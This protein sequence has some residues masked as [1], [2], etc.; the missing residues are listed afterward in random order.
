MV[1]IPYTVAQEQNTSVIRETPTERCERVTDVAICADV[2]WNYTRFPNMRG[3]A[4]LEEANRELEQFRQ[5]IETNCSGG[6][7]ILLCSIYT[8]FCTED[9]SEEVLFPPCMSLCQYVRDGCEP[10]FNQR[11]GGLHWPDHLNCDN[12]DSDLCFGPSDL[13]ELN[14]L[15]IPP[16]LVTPGTP[17]TVSTPTS[18]GSDSAS[19]PVTTTTVKPTSSDKVMCTYL[20]Q[21]LCRNTGG[22]S[23]TAFPN[24][25]QHQTQEEAAREM[26]KFLQVWSEDVP[27]SNAIVHFLCSFYFPFCGLLS[28]MN[29][30]VTLL[31]CRNLC[32]AVRAGCEEVT[33]K[34]TILGWP[35]FL[36]CSNFPDQQSELCF[37][38]E[39]PA[40]LQ[41]PRDLMTM[42]TDSTGSV[43]NSDRTSH[44]TP[45]VTSLGTILWL[46]ML[47]FILAL[48]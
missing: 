38:P 3:H 23:Q 22:Y 24:P 19:D 46:W 40:T 1:G 16:N 26:A 39:D 10:V 17:V 29:G 48:H 11:A 5:L 7:V 28:G 33:Q 8:P 30:N 45:H 14:K 37:G 42:A 35:E 34:H 43:P 18:G 15:V 41:L 4:N 2:P 47:V 13:E 12:Y 20:E 25:R 36:E 6:I 44:A 32:E 27:C 21:P 9:N 31:P